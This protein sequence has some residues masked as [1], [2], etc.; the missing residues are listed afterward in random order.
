MNGKSATAYTDYKRYVDFKKLEFIAGAIGG[1]APNGAWGLDAGCGRGSVTVPLAFLGYRMV[2]IDIFS[3]V[4]ER[5]RQNG[6]KVRDEAHPSPVFLLGDAESLPFCPG[7]F[8]F[9]ICSEILEHLH[10]P[11]RA[12]GEVF[13]AL[14]RG[15]WLIV[16]VP[17]GYGLHDLLFHH[18]RDLVA[19]MLPRLPS[20]ESVGGHVQAFTVGKIRRLV[21]EAGFRV[22]KTA[23]AD[24]LSWLPLLARSHWIGRVDC[25]L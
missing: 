19:R 13:A 4:V 9:A 7:S 23:N 17:N 24:F 2:G 10:S 6:T 8:D 18:L 3:S 20:S 12:L 14:K 25:R 1:L 5:A 11:E 22:V 21:E 15:G 16:T